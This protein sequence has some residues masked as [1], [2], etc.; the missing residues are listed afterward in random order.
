MVKMNFLICFGSWQCIE[1]P[2]VDMT[3]VRTSEQT[4]AVILRLA[5]TYIKG[6]SSDV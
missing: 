3:L 6:F 5:N 4:F 1:I 2:L